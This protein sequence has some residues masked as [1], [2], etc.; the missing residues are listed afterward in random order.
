MKWTTGWFY[1]AFIINTKHMEIETL[2]ESSW[3]HLKAIFYNSVCDQQCSRL[4]DRATVKWTSGRQRVLVQLSP[5]DNNYFNCSPKACWVSGKRKNWS[6]VEEMHAASGGQRAW[7]PANTAENLMLL[8][9]PFMLQLCFFQKTMWKCV[10][11]TMSIEELFVRAVVR[12]TCNALHPPLGD[13]VTWWAHWHRHTHTQ[14]KRKK[15]IISVF[16]RYLCL[17]SNIQL[18]K[19][20]ANLLGAHTH[21]CTHSVI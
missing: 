13:A 7:K 15:K 11:V 20:Y 12:V 18:K 8:V 9:R 2:M 21:T 19:N 17:F 1:S 10:T 6:G 3:L 5:P 16:T 14:R 4:G